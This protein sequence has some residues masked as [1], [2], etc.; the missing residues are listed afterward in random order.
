MPSPPRGGSFQGR[1]VEPGDRL[2]AS[3]SRLVVA[4]QSWPEICIAIAD[5]GFD[6]SRV[7]VW[8]ESHE[9]LPLLQVDPS[10]VLARRDEYLA[11]A[12][13]IRALENEIPDSGLS[14]LD[15]LE[16]ALLR[17]PS[18]GVALEFGVFRG[19]SLNVI[20][21]HR[22]VV[23]FDSFSGLPEDWTPRHPQGTFGLDAVPEVDERAE[24]V[25]GWFDDTLPRFLRDR[26]DA[27]I[28]FVHLD[29]DLYS[30]TKYVL[31]S[32]FD[33]MSSGCILLFDEFTPL[34]DDLSRG[35]YR[36]WSESVEEFGLRGEYLGRS[37]DR[38]ALRVER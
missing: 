4:S 3:I 33:R 16:H 14:R 9:D 35:E 20:A 17:A 22:P 18:G 27:L 15:F 38:V 6:M 26:S 7:E 21:K 31:S 32:I 29:A 8:T 13:L 5:S 1:Q 19:E 34:P 12:A 10:E 11:L 25:V 28:D 2:D 36:A 24:L 37:G 30:S 23:G